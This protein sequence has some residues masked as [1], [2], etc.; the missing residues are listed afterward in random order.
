MEHLEYNN[1]SDLQDKLEDF[2]DER[3][4]VGYMQTERYPITYTIKSSRSLDAQL[5][6]LEEAEGGIFGRD[7]R[8][9]FIFE[10]GEIT[11]KTIG[12]ASIP[13]ADLN[14][15]KNL[16]KKIHYAFLQVYYL[17]TE[18]VIQTAEMRTR[19]EILSRIKPIY[20]T[21]VGQICLMRPAVEE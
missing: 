19:E 16:V 18:K 12:R 1:L 6:M 4:L 15:I 3:H 5:S 14:K 8:I 2:L 21:T 20:D 11:F 7:A 9:V 17:D 13:D 10:D